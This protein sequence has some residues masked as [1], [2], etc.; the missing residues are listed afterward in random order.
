[1]GQR[2]FSRIVTLAEARHLARRALAKLD[3]VDPASVRFDEPQTRCRKYG[4]VLVFATGAGAGAMV[5]LHDASVVLITRDP[6]ATGRALVRFEQARAFVEEPSPRA[7]PPAA[8][9]QGR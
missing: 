4:W 1:M 6:S 7:T 9:Q 8:D 3:G 2:R 5:V